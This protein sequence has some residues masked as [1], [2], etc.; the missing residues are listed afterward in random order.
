MFDRSRQS[1]ISSFFTEPDIVEDNEEEEEIPSSYKLPELSELDAAKLMS[2]TESIKNVIGDSYPES[3][4]N[5]K[6]MEFN[7]NSEA[8]LNSILS[9]EVTKNEK[10]IYFDKF[11]LKLCDIKSCSTYHCVYLSFLDKKTTVEKNI[12]GAQAGE[13]S[14]TSF[15]LFIKI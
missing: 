9:D 6:I 12:A 11:K 10:G 14:E 8:V 2:C 3:E 1:N 5:K 4:L 15:D 7:F 13:K